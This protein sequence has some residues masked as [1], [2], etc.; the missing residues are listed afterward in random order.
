MNIAITGPTGSGK[1]TIGEALAKQL[2][3]CVSI[4]ADHIKHMLVN[5]FVKD[6]SNAGGWSFTEWALVG[7][8]I[9]LLT[10][11]FNDKGFSVIINGYIDEPAWSEIQRLVSLD[12]KILLLPDTN[13]NKARDAKRPEDIQMG[14]ASVEQHQDHF[15]SNKTYET[16]IKIDTSTDTV[17][18]TIKRSKDTLSI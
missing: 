12:R 2:D 14:E 1:T 6:D 4:D 10:K 13:T 3:K 7:E 17:E 8:S 15:R 18:Q 9:G 11:N 16:F 5:G